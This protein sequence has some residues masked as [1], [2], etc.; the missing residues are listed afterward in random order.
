MTTFDPASRVCIIGG[1]AAGVT[2]ALALRRR[3]YRDVTI[4]ERSPEGVG[5]KCRT[6]TRDGVALDTG[7]V[8]VLPNYPTVRGHLAT[9][10]MKLRVADPLIYLDGDGSR[11][12]FGVPARKISTW[13]KL[14]EYVRLGGELLRN[15]RMW[16]APLGALSGDRLQAA[17]V[18]LGAWLDR[19]RLEYF[20]TVAY[21]LLRCFG[22]G[23]EEQDIPMGYLFKM[24]PQLARNGNLASLWNPGGVRLHRLDEGYGALW[25]RLARGLDVRSG[26]TIS[27]V[28]RD[29]SGGGEVVSDAG[30]F[31][32]DA[33]I[34]ACPLDR[35]LGFLDADA[36][37]R[38]LFGRIQSFDVWHAAVPLQ[39]LPET[40]MFE[41]NQ[42]W[43]AR[44]RAMI[45]FRYQPG[46]PWYYLFGYGKP[47]Q[48]DAA[49]AR[50]LDADVRRHG[51]RLT[52]EPIIG[53]WS[54]L[55]HFGAADL[56]AGCLG[57]LEQRQGVRS[58]YYAGEVMAGIGVESAAV[59]AEHLVERQ[60]GER[61]TALARPRLAAR[62]RAER[63]V[64]T[65]PARAARGTLS[66]GLAPLGLEEALQR[67]PGGA[68]GE[69]ELVI[70]RVALPMLTEQH[71]DHPLADRHRDQ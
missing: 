21:P 63:R 50:D 25:Q 19:H 42:A 17:A 36:E 68:R 20:R 18:P 34:L 66:G 4:L 29:E 31:R 62:V 9:A 54:Y 61:A 23:Y 8:Y 24:L 69:G 39:G 27:Q 51:G 5:G 2:A 60:F 11:R 70:E 43:S 67:H 46:S 41:S 10:G 59:Y 13:S 52:G 22:F 28:T 37:E 64:A 48:D 40:A 55:P 16:S 45:A 3:G 32:F 6:I 1:G 7:A 38:D 12:P 26:V 35:T 33:L 65:A 49:I 44:G 71:P 15:R 57:R 53:R 30:R 14:A 58:T 56:A 47:G